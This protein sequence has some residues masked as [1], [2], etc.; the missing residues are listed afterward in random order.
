M[1][2]SASI[3]LLDHSDVGMSILVIGLSRMQKLLDLRWEENQ[4]HQL[5][6]FFLCNHGRKERS[7]E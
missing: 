7:D 4:P 2:V 5:L 3:Q 6:K 1:H